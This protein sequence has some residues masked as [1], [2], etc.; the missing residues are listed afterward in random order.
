MW[1][2]RA[3]GAGRVP[4][5][6]GPGLGPGGS[7][8]RVPGAEGGAATRARASRDVVAGRALSTPRATTTSLLAVAFALLSKAPRRLLGPPGP[9]TGQRLFS[10]WG[11]LGPRT[12]EAA[13]PPSRR[14]RP[15]VGPKSPP[16]TR[17][18][19]AFLRFLL[20]LF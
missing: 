6:L 8:P 7:A 3:S 13:G 11:P 12:L 4:G 5:A 1:P 2:S 9:G 16:F 19:L 17:R 18:R 10:G 14:R 15:P 20:K